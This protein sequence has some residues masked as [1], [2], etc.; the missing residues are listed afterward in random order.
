MKKLLILPFCVLLMASCTEEEDL[1]VLPEAD[2][3]ISNSTQQTASEQCFS[4]N[5]C[6]LDGAANDV[7]SNSN[8]A[9]WIIGTT[10][11]GGGYNIYN[12][13]FG[14]NT[15]TRVAG[16]A[17]AIDVDLNGIPWI[18]NNGGSIYRFTSSNTWERMPGSARDI[19]IGDDG[20]VWIIGTTKRSGGYNI[21]RW[22]PVS[23]NWRASSGSG[24]R[25]SVDNRG[26]PWVVN[27]EGKIFR[28]NSPDITI[29]NGWTRLPGEA[30][31]IGCGAGR[32]A[33]TGR[34]N[35]GGASEG[36]PIGARIYYFNGSDWTSASNSA[37]GFTIDVF[38][39]NEVAVVEPVLP[40]P[41]IARRIWIGR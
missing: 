7:G 24:V 18:V 31:D 25:I 34:T 5:W 15:W 4:T 32:V 17:I 14:N 22:D 2:V 41:F 33:I 28:R 38:S 9:L 26:V 13:N 40:K 10:S 6:L 19:G 35:G 27:D 23:R 21:Y 39:P 29:G 8:G 16:G 30:Y 20:S 1:A 3:P 37:G 11:V 12:R 36:V